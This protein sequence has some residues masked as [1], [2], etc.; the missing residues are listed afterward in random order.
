MV[1][2]VLVLAHCGAKW[3][4]CDVGSAVGIV[5]FLAFMVIGLKRIER[6]AEARAEELRR[7]RGYPR[8]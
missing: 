6:R 7:A 5:G 3:W 4:A 2:N 1:Q 8:Q